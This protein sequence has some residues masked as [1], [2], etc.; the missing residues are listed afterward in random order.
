MT[1]TVSKWLPAAAGTEEHFIIAKPDGHGSFARQVDQ[2][3]DLYQTAL[4]DLGLD[5]ASAVTATVFLSDS[6]NQESELRQHPA[7]LRLAAG[8]GAV[9]VIQQPPADA[10]LGLLVYHAPRPQGGSRRSLTSVAGAAATAAGLVVTAGDYEFSYLRNLLSSGQGDAGMQTDDLLGTPGCGAQSN[11][12]ALAQVVRTWLY[13]NN[14][15]TNYAPIS[16]ARN[17]LFERF[18]IDE[19][20]G[21][22]ASTGIEGR[23]ADHRDLLLLDVLAIKG[24]QPG[25]SQG[26]EVTTHMNS[27]VEYGVTFERGRAVTFGDRRHLYISGTASIDN[28]GQILHPGDV[29]RQTERAVENVGALL[30]ASDAALTDMR[31]LLVYLRDSVD[32]DAV[33]AVIAASPLATVPRII[34]RAPVCRPGWLVEIEGVAI[35]GKGDPR[36]AP[37]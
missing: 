5:A 11:G 26:M 25:Q 16:T 32:A 20:S 18:G 3:F 36:F 23:S 4:A 37:F 15:D 14:I 21:F 8:G 33:E 30:A 22:P 13:I 2:T 29:G 34:V 1:A 28:K 10:K 17:A 7:F 35:D 9:T 19:H 24:L 27:T 6:A 12:T 31:Y